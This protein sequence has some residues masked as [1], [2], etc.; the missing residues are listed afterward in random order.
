MSLVVLRSIQPQPNLRTVR[1]AIQ[2]QEVAAI[3]IGTEGGER[4]DFIDGVRAAN[5]AASSPPTRVASDEYNIT[6]AS[7][8]LALHANEPR[9]KTEDQD[10]A[11]ALS[12]W[13]VNVD[14][15]LDRGVRN[16]GLS[17]IA[18]FWSVVN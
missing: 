16:G 15:E 14:P 1:E 9:L 4:I 3:Q 12:D 6:V 13:P 2:R 8:P 11:P 7:G 17:A 18:P 10:V 5:H